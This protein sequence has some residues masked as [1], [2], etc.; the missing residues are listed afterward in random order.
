MLGGRAAEEVFFKEQSVGASNDIER[1]TDIAKR[2]VT[3][4][5]MSPLGPINYVQNEDRKWLAMQLGTHNEISENKKDQI[6]KEIEKIIL[7]GKKVAE[8]II[9]KHKKQMILVSEELI[10]V[11]T[12][13]QDDFEKLVGA[14]K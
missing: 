7:A 8:E 9:K 6:D 14:K 12:L 1:A 3:E 10:K 4:W 11:E 13:E 5:G 2:M